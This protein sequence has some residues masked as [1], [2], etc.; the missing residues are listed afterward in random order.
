MELQTPL[1]PLTVRVVS[2]GYVSG[3]I[4]L[5]H[6]TA[7]TTY[8]FQVGADKHWNGVFEASWQVKAMKVGGDGGW[9]YSFRSKGWGDVHD[10]IKN[11]VHPVLVDWANANPSMFRDKAISILKRRIESAEFELA[12]LREK[13]AALE[14]EVIP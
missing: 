2:D 1:G 10:R 13:L 5:K 14:A 9:K 7:G 11:E 3:Q 12:D 4:E 6:P 8:Q